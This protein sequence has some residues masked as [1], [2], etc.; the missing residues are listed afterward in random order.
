MAILLERYPEAGKLIKELIWCGGTQRH[1]SLQIVKDVQTYLD[2]EAA[3]YVLE[4]GLNFTMCPVDAGTFCYRSLS[5][6]DS[7]RYETEPVMHQF[8]R[9]LKKR[10]CDVNAEAP[11]GERKRHLP[12]QEMAAV[13]AAVLPWLCEKK[14]RYGE[15]DLKGKLTFGMLVIDINNRLEHTEEEMNIS[16]VCHIDRERLIHLLYMDSGQE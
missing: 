2:P 4:Q 8:N 10:W 7:R 9:L 6:V 12:M 13:A 11:M 16:Q 1:A 3:Q 14:K 15:V 5:E